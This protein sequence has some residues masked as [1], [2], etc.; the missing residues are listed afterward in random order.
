MDKKIF[1][2]IIAAVIGLTSA[3]SIKTNPEFS[4]KV[5]G[6]VANYFENENDLLN[7]FEF[8]KGQTVAEIGTFDGANI[9]GFSILTDSITFYAQ[10]IDSINLTQK[11]FDKM[12]K[13]CTKYKK[14]LTN[15]FH[16]CI[17]TVKST[18]LP[19]NTFDKI[20]LIS[21]IHEF[22]F[23]D[24]MMTDIYRKLKPSGQLYILET[25]C[26]SHQNYQT[27]DEMT[28]MMKKYN[29]HL[30]KKDGKD[31]NNSLGLYRTVFSKK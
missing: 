23:M 6:S 29:F 7:F 16:L 26:D 8:K 21:T 15:K 28:T 18:N 12:I 19:D 24:E 1:T 10:D 5:Y 3:I 25:R 4:Y 17:G 20:L 14:R 31:I 13:H 9:G 30:V 27:A 22:T 2:L 11:K